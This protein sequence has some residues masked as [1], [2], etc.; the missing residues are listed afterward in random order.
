MKKNIKSIGIVLAIIIALLIFLYFFYII[1]NI[2]KHNQNLKKYNSYE[3]CVSIYDFIEKDNCYRYLAEN[4]NNQSIC[5]LIE[6]DYIK[7]ECI[8]SF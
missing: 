1:Y 8:F 3:T 7:S 5:N 2:Y 6:N 4:T